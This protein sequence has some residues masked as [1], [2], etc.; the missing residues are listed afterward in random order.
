MLQVKISALVGIAVLVVLGLILSGGFVIVQ[1]GTVGV[2]TKFG[3]VQD[4]I[5]E[6][7]LHFK[8]PI[9]TR[10]VPIDTRVQKVEDE[11]T[12]SSKDLQIVSSRVALNYAVDK[13]E[14][15]T[16][17]SDLGM[18]FPE[19]IVSPAIQESIKSTTSKY[20]AEQ[21]ITLRAE[22][23]DAVLQDIRERL[24]RSNILVTEFSIIDFNFSEEFNRAIEEK[25]VAEQAAL[26]AKNELERV[27]I[28]ADQVKAKAEGEAEAKLAKAKAE[29]EAQMLLRE[30]LTPDLLQLRAIE[31]WDGVL[32]VYSGGDS[33][34]PFLALP[35]PQT[36]PQQLRTTGL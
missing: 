12:A 10:V 30:T 8:V 28:E 15:N 29:S 14:A 24:A 6:P 11:A 36:K 32:P 31:Q 23:K 4:E 19:R 7:G 34:A 18:E 27:K 35:Q 9:M 3:K 13:A 16:V 2:V 5:M 26:R 22:V 17:Y 33:P 20:T 21:L 25:Q 1:P